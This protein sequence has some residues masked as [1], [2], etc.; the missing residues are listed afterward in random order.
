MRVKVT[1]V[2]SNCPRYAHRFEKVKA[3]RYV[4]RAECPTPLAGWK[5]IDL[6]Q[7]DLPGKDVGRAAKEGG[8]ISIE[9][10]FGKVGTGAEDA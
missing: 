8:L 7:A 1:E 6:I 3:S 9:D 2:W 5:H 4:P 10:W